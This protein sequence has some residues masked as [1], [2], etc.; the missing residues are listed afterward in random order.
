MKTLKRNFAWL[1]LRLA[2]M[3]S[4][5]KGQT[6]IEYVLV[7]VLAVIAIVLALA[8][9]RLEDVVNAASNKISEAIS[10]AV[11]TT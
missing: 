7:I 9:A 4:N 11:V 8:S 1:N 10:A 3:W 6:A 2:A 5:E